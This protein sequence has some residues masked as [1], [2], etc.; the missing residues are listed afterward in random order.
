MEV[1][2][3]VLWLT[4]LMRKRED[5]NL[6]WVLRVTATSYVDERPAVEICHL[7]QMLSILLSRS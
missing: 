2:A 4:V 7:V 5:D 6:F 1:R 3:F